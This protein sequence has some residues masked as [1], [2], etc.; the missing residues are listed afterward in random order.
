M[1]YIITETDS[2]SIKLDF[3]NKI[4]LK[5]KSDINEEN[6]DLNTIIESYKQQMTLEELNKFIYKLIPKNINDSFKAKIEQSK[7]YKKQ[8]PFTNENRIDSINRILAK[9]FKS[10]FAF[11]KQNLEDVS[12]ILS[13]IFETLKIYKIT[14]EKILKEK[15]KN[16][17]LNI[18]DIFNMF[19]DIDLINK[20][21]SERKYRL[22]NKLRMKFYGNQ[23]PIFFNSTGN[24]SIVQELHNEDN[25]DHDELKYKSKKNKDYLS[26]IYS[27]SSENEESEEDLK[28]SETKGQKKIKKILRKMSKKRIEN[29]EKLVN[30]NKENKK[31]RS[32]VNLLD[33]D[34]KIL[35]TKEYFIYPE[36]NYGLDANKM[37]LPIELIILLKKF[38]N[39]KILT[40]QIRDTD[41]KSLKENILL[42]S[43]IDLL[44]PNFSEIKIDLNDENL[45][46]KINSLYEIRGRDLVNKFKKDLTIV[47]IA[48]EYKSRTINCWEPEGDIIFVT[49]EDDENNII[50]KYTSF[51]NNYVLGENPFENSNFFGNN[52]ENI[53]TRDDNRYNNF[54]GKLNSIK[55]IIPMKNETDNYFNDDLMNENEEYERDDYS[56]QPNN[57][58]LRS[59]SEYPKFEKST[60]SLSSV[61]RN[62]SYS[63]LNFL[64]KPNFDNKI[65]GN[66][67]RKK[68]TPE[69]LAMF[70][71][72]N[73]AP[74]EMILI[75]C[76]FLDKISKIKTLSLYFYDSFSIETEFFLRNEKIRF[77]GFHFLF[78]INK[79]KELE[80]VNFS[81]NSLDT[82]SFENILGLIELNKNISKLR[83]N[84]FTSDIS[85]N[86]TNLLKLC[87]NLKLS[88]QNIFKE[89]IVNYINEKEPKDFALEYFILNHKLDYY[90][91]K[92]ICGLFNIIK[93]NI[94]NNYKEIVF[95]FDL[96][97]LI[98][99]S[100]KYIIIIIK[101]FMNM[102][103]LISFSANQIK[104]FKFISPELILDG[105]LTP[106]LKY[107]FKE[108]NLEQ[109]NVADNSNNL[110]INLK[111]LNKSL[112]T[113]TLQCKIF[114]IPKIFNICLSNNIGGLTYVSIRDLD[115]ES[116][117]GFLNDYKKNVDKMNNLESLKVGLN[118]TIISY[119]KVKNEIKEFIN[120]NSIKLKEKILFSNLEVDNIDKI[121]ELK[122]YVQKANIEKVVVQIGSSNNLLLYS[123]EFN[124]DEKYKMELEALY[125]V[126][127]KKP[128]NILIKD[129]IIINLKRY[130]KKNKNRV[131]ICKP[132]F[133]AYDSYHELN[134]CK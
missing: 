59:S 24:L 113:F 121:N 16:I 107:F 33:E 95:R 5:N 52:L 80:E 128:Y 123:S 15:I 110:K 94:N 47:Q 12:I 85:F 25:F 96:P 20:K 67:M 9:D 40:F 49:E 100:D 35:I 129:K 87:S 120:V 46:K 130:F 79:I 131:V 45:Q 109:N 104:T 38:E 42:L 133:Y 4:R 74:F 19:I 17:K 50:Y 84:F 119:D 103:N 91:E 63:N 64:K 56:N 132:S 92:N 134:K 115:L 55:Y 118:N 57:I 78:F 43:N 124:D 14:N 8:N 112:K 101:F 60:K 122:F 82:R 61:I 34:N 69:L 102:L 13:Y 98:L 93:K 72:E 36:N 30:K 26:K 77:E 54:G 32:N 31:K 106:C 3:I 97:L 28:T 41:K 76:W 81:F 66:K 10:N 126:L 86:I 29:M 108:L 7:Q 73:E 90:F 65:K 1:N 116:F 89:H 37:E 6:S 83:I 48:Q 68:T 70:I 27:S 58:N 22:K 23:N 2:N 117:F 62:N 11:N 51:G 18:H 105:R 39:I 127:T 125:F 71:K 75:Y 111:D 114:R 88:L 44:F 21:K 99:S 53:I